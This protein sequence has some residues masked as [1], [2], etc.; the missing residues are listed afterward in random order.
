[1]PIESFLVVG[2]VLAAFVAFAAVISFGDL[3]LQKPFL[4]R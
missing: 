2:A 1:M 4:R 3:T